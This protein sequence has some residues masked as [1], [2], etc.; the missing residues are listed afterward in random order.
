MILT[1]GQ[2]YVGTKEVSKEVTNVKEFDEANA[3][4]SGMR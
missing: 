4:L 3:W 2:L 1:R